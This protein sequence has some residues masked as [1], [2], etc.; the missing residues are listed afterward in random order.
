MLVLGLGSSTYKGGQ[1]I[2]A[3]RDCTEKFGAVNVWDNISVQ[4][5][6]PARGG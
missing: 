2:I 4:V 3:V 6:R 1:E 5:V